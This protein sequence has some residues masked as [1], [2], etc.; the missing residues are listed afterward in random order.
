MII[1]T[2]FQAGTAGNA[3]TSYALFVVG[4]VIGGVGNGIVTSSIPTYQAECA[5]S[6]RRGFLIM[7]SGSLIA[8]GIMI[9]Y[10][11]DYVSNFR[12]RQR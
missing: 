5:K 4:R 11:V 6:H 2:V 7:L 12:D 8:A 1:G 9:S 3:S 10:W